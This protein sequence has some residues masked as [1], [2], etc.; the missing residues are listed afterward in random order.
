MKILLNCINYKKY[1]WQ[2]YGN[3]KFVAIFLGL[4]RGYRKVCCLLCEWDSRGEN[5]HYKKS[6]WPSREL[7]EPGTKNV[8][9]LPLVESSKTL[10]PPLHIQLRL[11]KNLV[12][13][14]DQT[15]PTFVYLA[16]KFPGI[17]AAKIK[18][19]VFV[20]PQTRRLSRKE[21]FDRILRC[22][23]K[24]AW[25]DFRVLATNFMGNNKADNYNVYNVCLLIFFGNYCQSSLSMAIFMF[26]FP[27]SMKGKI[28]SQILYTVYLQ[29][30]LWI[31][32]D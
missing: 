15:W 4:Q 18:E 24:R 25:N 31:L 12:K 5:C 32:Y 20:G 3:L 26:N 1:Q 21:R 29:S 30:L 28:I 27:Q 13:A 23:E 6:V 2:F 19:G 17:S 7:R 14:M 16:E 10:L 11:I 8:Q 22:N 9:H